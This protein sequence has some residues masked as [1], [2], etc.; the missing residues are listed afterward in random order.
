MSSP[1]LP[2]ALIS[3]GWWMAITDDALGIPYRLLALQLGRPMAI[4]EAEF[5]VELPSLKDE[6]P[7]FSSRDEGC[8]SSGPSGHGCLMA[9]FLEVI[10]FSHIVGFVIHGLYRPSQ[11]DLSPDQMLESASTLDQ[12]LLKWKTRL[13]RQLRFD[14][15][16]TFEK[17]LSFKRQ[18]LIHQSLIASHLLKTISVIC[19]L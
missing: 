6:S 8:R 2:L 9:Y 10:Q 4:H 1:L 18:L 14:L 16:H 5:Q 15:G 13:P 11:V 19:L 17:S 12:H 7:F 3:P